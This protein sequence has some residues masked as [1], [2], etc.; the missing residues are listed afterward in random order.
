MAITRFPTGS[1]GI[2]VEHSYCLDKSRHRSEEHVSIYIP[3]QV[4][5]LCDRL[6]TARARCDGMLR[7]IVQE[8]EKK[9]N[10]LSMHIEEG[11]IFLLA[12]RK[13]GKDWVISAQPRAPE[14]AA[15]ARLRSHSG[16]VFT[17]VRQCTL[18]T[19]VARSSAV[20]VPVTLQIEHMV[21]QGSD[22]LP[23]LNAMMVAVPYMASSDVS[24]ESSPSS[25]LECSSTELAKQL[26][27]A[28]DTPNAMPRRGSVVLE[29]K[30]PKWN[31][32]DEL[33]EL[34][35]HG[36]ANRASERN[37]QLTVLDGRQGTD[38]KTVLLH[39]KLDE[40]LFALDFAYPLSPLHAFAICCSTFS[41]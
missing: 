38:G 6:M 15:L 9:Q 17:C 1:A 35:F 21:D 26:R 2:I 20:G 7:C 22:D 39:G 23:E 27:I 25:E 4:D 5:P 28:N 16:G 14:R 13:I 18:A 10:E 41:W 3:E 8:N 11:N 33:Y 12:A 29:T 36:R 30:R 37:L 31:S 24:D 40:R 19:A 32:Q 34:P